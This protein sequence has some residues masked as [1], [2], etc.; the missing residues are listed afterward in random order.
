MKPRAFLLSIHSDPSVA[1]V[2]FKRVVATHALYESPLKG[3]PAG[4]FYSAAQVMW[5]IGSALIECGAIPTAPFSSRPR[6]SGKPLSFFVCQLDQYWADAFADFGK[7]GVRIYIMPILGAVEG[8][9]DGV[10]D[11]FVAHYAAR[12]SALHAEAVAGH[13]VRPLLEVA[14]S[15]ASLFEP[16]GIVLADIPELAKWLPLICEASEAVAGRA[17]TMTPIVPVPKTPAPTSEET[18]EET[19]VEGVELFEEPL[20][21]VFAIPDDF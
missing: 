13:D 14:L 10:H 8:M 9:P 11:A 7:I 16:S 6:N 20:P 19:S 1:V 2:P 21:P 18:S 3:R 5:K 15:L 17:L 4:K 12:L